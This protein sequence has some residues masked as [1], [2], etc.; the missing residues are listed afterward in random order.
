MSQTLAKNYLHLVFS[1]KGRTDTLPKRHLAEV[2]AYM[3]GI[4]KQNKCPA[5][6]VGGTSNHIH[7][8][9]CLDRTKNLSDVVRTVKS[10]TSQWI[11]ERMA[12]PFSHFCWQDG[13]GAFSISQSHVAA[14]TQYIKCQEEHHKKVSFQDEFRRICQ[15]YKVGL[16]ERYVWD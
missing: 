3:A 6:C 16:D 4:L 7:I 13:Y 14:V 1:T 8:L 12:S 15:L 2:H 11:N 9:F 10:C 5:L